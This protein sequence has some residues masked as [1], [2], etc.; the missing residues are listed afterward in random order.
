MTQR[1]RLGELMLIAEPGFGLKGSGMGES[2]TKS[3]EA[4]V[5][6]ENLRQTAPTR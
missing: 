6:L 4:A 5:F 3:L 2:S 1:S